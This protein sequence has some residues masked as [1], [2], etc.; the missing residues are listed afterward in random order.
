MKLDDPK[1]LRAAAVAPMT[2]QVISE[3][4]LLEKYAKGNEQNV[5]G[6]RRRVARAHSC[7]PSRMA[8]SWGGGSIPPRAPIS[9]PR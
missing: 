5:D 9:R 2:P 6:V 7:R 3:E 1:T 8:S 4:V